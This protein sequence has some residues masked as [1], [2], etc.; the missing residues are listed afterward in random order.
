M[1]HIKYCCMG[2]G[3]LFEWLTAALRLPHVQL[4]RSTLT[5]MQNL[6][7]IVSLTHTV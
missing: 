7:A 6:H 5:A 3:M 2:G 4:L 1:E